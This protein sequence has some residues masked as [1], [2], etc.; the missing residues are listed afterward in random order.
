MVWIAKTDTVAEK[1]LAH[2]YRACRSGQG[3]GRSS[4][5]VTPSTCAMA[6]MFLRLG[7]AGVPGM[8]SPFSNFW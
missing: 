8:D 6:M 3:S 5:R 1:S 4:S 2:L 7:L